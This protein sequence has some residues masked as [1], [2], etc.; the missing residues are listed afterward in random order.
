MAQVGIYALDR[1][2]LAFVRKSLVASRI[3]DQRVV[4][5][6]IVRVVLLGLWTSIEN[7][8]QVVC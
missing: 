2:G 5:G 1:V 8:L 3:V 4:G 6:E 7:S